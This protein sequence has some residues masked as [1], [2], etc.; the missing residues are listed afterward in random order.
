MFAGLDI[1]Y[2][3]RTVKYEEIYIHNYTSPQEARQA[4]TDY[5]VYYNYQRPHQ[6]LGCQIP[7]AIHFKKTFAQKQN[8]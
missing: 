5:F 8:E 7:T 4:L 2:V 3:W 6:A 1:T